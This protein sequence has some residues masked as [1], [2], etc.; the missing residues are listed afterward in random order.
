MSLNPVGFNSNLGQNPYVVTTTSQNPIASNKVLSNNFLNK[1][2][3]ET[4]SY[5]NDILMAGIDFQGLAAAMNNNLTS[6]NTQPLRNVAPVSQQSESKEI[7]FSGK[8]HQ[9][10]KN[11]KDELSNSV[12]KNAQEQ[13]KEENKA[14]DSSVIPIIGGIVGAISPLI[15]NYVHSGKIFSKN[16]FIKMPIM[17][18]GGICIGGILKGLNYSIQKLTNS[19]EN[20]V[21]S[22]TVE[23]TKRMDAKA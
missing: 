4:N 2:L 20:D 21:S 16:L 18:V 13:P 14:N 15:C 17:A 23:T 9:T 3:P 10:Q 19:K 22:E 7:S 8:E 12:V 11:T 1:A 5:Q 6:S